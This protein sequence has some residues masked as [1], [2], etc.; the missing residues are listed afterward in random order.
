M[1]APAPSPRAAPPDPRRTSFTFLAGDPSSHQEPTAEI[2]KTS[3]VVTSWSFLPW[4]FSPADKATTPFSSFAGVSLWGTARPEAAQQ[5]RLK[6]KEF[7]TTEW[8]M[9]SLSKWLRVYDGVNAFDKVYNSPSEWLKAIPGL[10]AKLASL[11]DI[12]PTESDLAD[13]DPFDPRSGSGPNATSS[14]CL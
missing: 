10:K 2:D 12:R 11:D 8:D 14:T 13:T 5:A 7:L 6:T 4:S 1:A 3:P 9:G